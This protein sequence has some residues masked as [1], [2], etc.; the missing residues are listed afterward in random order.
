V[1]GG[2]AAGR[3]VDDLVGDPSEGLGRGVVTAVAGLVVGLDAEDGGDAVDLGPASGL[4]VFEGVGVQ[5]QPYS[6]TGTPGWS[7]R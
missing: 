4:V 5:V 7:W 2:L 1:V 6:L 3:D